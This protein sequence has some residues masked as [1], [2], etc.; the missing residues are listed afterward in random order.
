M[1]K[2]ILIA[3]VVVAVTGGAFFGGLKYQQGKSPANFGQA[4]RDGLQNGGQQING[5]RGGLRVAG[6]G[7]VS[8]EIISKD[9]T[10]ITV[11]LADGGSKI[12]FL[13]NTTEISKFTQGVGE[14]LQ[15]GKSISVN[16]K[17]NEDGSVTAQTI[18]LRPNMPSPAPTN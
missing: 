12:I 18:Q 5:A 10:S 14:D 2:K 13:S 17:A 1:N 9:A 15:V 4:F 3:A 7:F 16:G 8:G 6:G 11:K